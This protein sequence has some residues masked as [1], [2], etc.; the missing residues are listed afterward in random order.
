MRGSLVGPRLG[1]GDRDVD[2]SVIPAN[3]GAIVKWPKTRASI[4][5]VAVDSDTIDARDDLVRWSRK[6]S[7]HLQ[8]SWSLEDGF[9]FPSEPG[10]EVPPYPNG[11]SQAFIDPR[12]AEAPS[13][14]HL[15]SLRHFQAT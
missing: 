13:D 1:R 6:L 11:L 5:Q 9:V 3:G 2:E 10:G 12:T 4:R 14:I 7:P 15:H 8:R